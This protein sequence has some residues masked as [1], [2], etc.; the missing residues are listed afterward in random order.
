VGR[1]RQGTIDLDIGYRADAPIPVKE[2]G[3]TVILFHRQRYNNYSYYQADLGKDK[4][5]AFN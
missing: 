4:L 1:I 2:T 3:I 5:D